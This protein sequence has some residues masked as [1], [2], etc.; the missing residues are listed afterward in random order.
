MI[1]FAF[2]KIEQTNQISAKNSSLTILKTRPLKKFSLA[3]LDRY[4]FVIY[5]NLSNLFAFQVNI[6]LFE[7]V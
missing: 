5:L 6:S 2:E 1:H 3:L 7:D 4:F